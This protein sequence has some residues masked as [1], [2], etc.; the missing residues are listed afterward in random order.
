MFKRDVKKYQSFAGNIQSLKILVQIDELLKEIENP[1]TLQ[2]SF[3]E[4]AI[5]VSSQVEPQPIEQIEVERFKEETVM[6]ETEVIEEYIY[7]SEP[8]EEPLELEVDE[9]NIS[10]QEEFSES[11]TVY[12]VEVN[13]DDELPRPKKQTTRKYKYQI[14]TN[15]RL[16]DEE[17]DWINKQ[18]R[19]CTVEIDGKTIYKCPLCETF[20]KISGSFKKHLRDTH[21]LKNDK[22]L[23]LLNKRR[24]FKDEI[25]QSK[26]VVETDD[27]P[28]TIWKCQRCKYDRIFRS[29]AGLKVHIR[30][31]HIRT[32]Q[33]DLKFVAQC[34]VVIETDQGPKD[35][36]RCPDCFKE[37]RSR[38]GL[39]NHMKLAHPETVAEKDT[40]GDEQCVRLNEKN[41]STVDALQNLLERKRR[42]LKTDLSTTTCLECGIQFMNG[43]SKKEKSC[44]I[45]QECHKILNI[46]SQ[47]YQLPKSDRDKVMFSNNDDLN[48]YLSSDQ[49]SFEVLSCDGMTTKVSQ[50]FKEPIGTSLEDDSWK[51]GHC[52]V[53][54][55]TEFE[56]NAHVMILHSKKLICP[57]DHMEFEGNRGIS[58]FNIHMHNKH[59]EFFPDL[60]ISCT[61][62]SMGNFASHFEK[63]EHMR[64]CSEKKFICD[65]CGRKYFTKTELLRHLK[66]AVGE[67]KYVCNV[68]SK[69]CSSTMDLR[70][71]QTSHT[72][73]KAYLCSYPECNKAFKTPAARSSHMETH[74]NV[75]Y[76]CSICSAIFKQRALL[77]RHIKK[78]FCNAKEQVESYE[79]V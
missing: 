39:R 8:H 58:Q 70:L 3:K 10:K 1:S 26:M 76:A 18:V 12:N 15:D 69:N 74:G 6:E 68:C 37:L 13:A 33:I 79:N 41:H 77:Q 63:L 60:V 24:A 20:L 5:V 43:T 30:Y 38:D 50:K 42:T 45:H 52:G 34:K 28:E 48:K 27:G 29:E 16:T 67:I 49:E 55:Q 31:S 4:N 40:M 51:C 64:T 59:A 36:W 19:Q 21:I 32:G 44:R 54:Y 65:H 35:A 53:K 73:Q 25:N 75:S 7:D 17:K 78:G 66:I 72:N 61:F 46:M 22:A 9:T 14:N 56:C 2:V 62:C 57:V 71:H 47:Y 23:S 11:E